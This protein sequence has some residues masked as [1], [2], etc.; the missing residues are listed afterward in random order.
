[1][2]AHRNELQLETCEINQFKQA[3]IDWLKTVDVEP[4]FTPVLVN[5]AV[6]EM[7]GCR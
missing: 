5:G 1:M 3:S 2:V 4:K 7:E 6:K